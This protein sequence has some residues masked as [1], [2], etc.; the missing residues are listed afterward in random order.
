VAAAGA[1]E[2]AMPATAVVAKPVP[3]AA[4]DGTAGTAASAPTTSNSSAPAWTSPA[5][6]GPHAIAGFKALAAGIGPA[7]GTPP[8]QG[9][10]NAIG[11]GGGDSAP[12]VPGAPCNA[13]GTSASGVGGTSGGWVALPVTRVVCWPA[14]ALRRLQLPAALWRPAAF[15]SLQERPG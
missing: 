13:G 1:F 3:S 5:L 14:S 2:P 8:V 6:I 10:K 4:A 15:V 12:T 11:A 9:G 7:A